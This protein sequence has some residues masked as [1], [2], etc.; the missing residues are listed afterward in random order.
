MISR[1]TGLAAAKSRGGE[2]EEEASW[3]ALRRRDLLAERGGRDFLDMDEMVEDPDANLGGRDFLDLEEVE[4][5]ECSLGGSVFLVVPRD[6][7]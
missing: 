6:A 3:T 1:P 7:S 5:P 4:D 2:P